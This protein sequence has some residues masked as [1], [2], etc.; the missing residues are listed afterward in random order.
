MRFLTYNIKDG[1]SGRE[2]LIAQIIEASRVDVVV[3]QEVTTREF[4]ERLAEQLALHFFFAQGN[5]IRHLGILSR[6]PLS[7]C[8]SYH[9]FPLQHALLEAEIEVSAHQ[10]I[11]IFGIHLSAPAFTLASELYRQWE[12]R[13][14][15]SRIAQKSPKAFIM[16]GDCNAIAPNDTVE[17]SKLPFSLRLSIL[18]HGNIIFRQAIQTIER[19]GLVDAF[20]KMNP[21]ASGYTL[22]AS[23]PNARL[24][25]IFVNSAL[26]EKIRVCEPVTQPPDVMRA[27]DH[28]PLLME[29]DIG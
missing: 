16:A 13:T 18:L 26:A 23:V 27:S 28:L 29:I 4:V 15:L 12:A 14:I 24:D 2:E 20:R 21:D 11:A 17:I 6:L 22:P 25:Y 7:N 19:A 1:G 10:R 5:S 8:S 3:L 9:P